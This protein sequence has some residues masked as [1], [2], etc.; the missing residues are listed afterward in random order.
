MRYVCDGMKERKR[1]RKK[2]MSEMPMVQALD[3]GTNS[4]TAH[5]AYSLTAS[6]KEIAPIRSSFY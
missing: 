3:N 2:G 4:G 5:T 6:D 1:E